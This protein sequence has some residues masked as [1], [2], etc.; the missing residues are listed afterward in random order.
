MPATR[1]SPLGVAWAQT[2]PTRHSFLTVGNKNYRPASTPL[3]PSCYRRF[4]EF[5]D[6]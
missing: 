1:S 3:I 4:L 2:G 5:R 6:L